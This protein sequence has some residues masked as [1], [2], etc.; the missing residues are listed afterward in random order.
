MAF[1]LHSKSGAAIRVSGGHWAVF[2]TLAER[3]GWKPAGTRRPEE[4]PATKSWAGPY[5]TNDGQI[6]EDADAKRLAQ[7]LHAA[8]TSDKLPVALADVIRHIE[9]QVEDS[10]TSI[11]PQ[12]RMRPEDF[13]QKFSPLLMFLYQGEFNID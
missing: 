8:A 9:N 3:Y 12:M 7:V 2:L 6:V 11:P 4:Y 5:D 13:N 1:D 10:G